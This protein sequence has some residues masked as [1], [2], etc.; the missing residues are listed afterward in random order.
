VWKIKDKYFHSKT[1]NLQ[2]NLDKETKSGMV[3]EIL[4][5]IKEKS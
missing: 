1:L 4:N 5:Q 3:I 2:K